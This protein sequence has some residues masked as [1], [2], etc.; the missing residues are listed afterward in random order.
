LP[1]YGTEP[2]SNGR[3]RDLIVAAVFLVVAFSTLFL[4]RPTQRTVSTALQMSVLRPFIGIQRRLEFARTRAERVDSMVARIDSLSKLLASHSALADENR[5]LRS[6]LEL[7]ERAGPEYVPATVLRP[8]TPGSESMFILDVG[9]RDGVRNGSAVVGPFGLLGVIREVRRDDAVGMD[10]SH[11]DFRV[12]AMLEDGSAYGLVSR[13]AGAFREKDRLL[14]NGMPFNLD[15]EYGVTVVTSGL[16]GVFPRGIPI[17]QVEE[18][19]E[20]ELEWRKSY[21]LKPVVEPASATH[22]LVLTEEAAPEVSGLWAPDS[23]R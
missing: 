6:L 16:G 5:T 8:G 9:S 23:I 14:L 21:W 17:G 4:S 20:T 11:P 1:P 2:E 7:S 15:V 19:A 22:V 10:W 18:E 12:S 3:H 13:Q